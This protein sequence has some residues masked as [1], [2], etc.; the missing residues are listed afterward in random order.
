M[1]TISQR[2]LAR[3]KQQG[4]DMADVAAFAAF[5]DSDLTANRPKAHQPYGGHGFVFADG[6]DGEQT[7]AR[8]YDP[9]LPAEKQMPS[10]NVTGNV[11]HSPGSR[12]PGPPAFNVTGDVN[13]Y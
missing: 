1:L 5:I 12:D 6:D 9:A 8:L 13:N 4:G 3:Y 10:F 11:G 7:I 2:A